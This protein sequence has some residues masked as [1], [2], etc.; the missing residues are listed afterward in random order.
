MSWGL[1]IYTDRA[2]AGRSLARH[3]VHLK[4]RDAL[5]LAVPNGGVA[6]AAPL[7]RALGAPLRLMVVRKVQI[8]GNSEAGFGAVGA[9][10]AVVL[11]HALLDRLR[12]TPEQL[13]AQIE[14]ARHSVTE[15]R[16]AYGPWTT[17]PP[18]AGR[19]V[20]LVDDGL[21][22]GSTMEAAVRLVK[23]TGAAHV[24]AAAPTCSQRACRRLEPLVDEL[25]CPNLRK[26][27]VF[28]VA[29][30]YRNWYDVD[31]AEVMELLGPYPPEEGG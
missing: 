9:S 3:L 16:T 19:T 1:P 26:G 22:S 23:A 31:T 12:L 18:L 27:P 30:A 6:V 17:L 24:V 10:G 28:A 25:I 21:A 14:Q 4:G 7:A 15:R 11:D 20:I 13:Q 2:E 29:D 8:P 5:I